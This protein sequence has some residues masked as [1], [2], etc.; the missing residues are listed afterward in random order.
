MGSTV[1]VNSV[2]QEKENK[3]TKN[4]NNKNLSADLSVCKFV[5]FQLAMREGRKLK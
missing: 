2:C 4:N 1:L 5:A 3:Q